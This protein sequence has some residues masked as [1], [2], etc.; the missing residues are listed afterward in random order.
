MDSYQF[1]ATLLVGMLVGIVLTLVV[2]IISG[3][4]PVQVRMQTAIEFGLAE[5]QCDA[6]H[7]EIV[8]VK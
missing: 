2:I 1:V 8:W 6:G 5:Y 7:C 4:A 3:N